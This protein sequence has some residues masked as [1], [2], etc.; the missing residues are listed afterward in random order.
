MTYFSPQRAE[1]SLS[2]RLD[3]LTKLETA[4]KAQKEQL[5]EAVQKDLNKPRFEFFAAELLAILD[6]IRLFKGK[7]AKWMKP[8]RVGSNFF[9]F[10][11]K[12]KIYPE[13]YGNVLII[14]PWNYPVQLAILPLIG[15]LAAG[16]RVMLK[17]SPLCPHVSDVLANLL[18]GCFAEDLVKVS[19]GDAA[20]LEAIMAEKW[21]YIFFTGST[22]TGQKVMQKAAETL[23]PVTL[24]LGGKSPALILPDANITRTARRIVWGKFIN[25]G[26][27]CVAPDYVL[28][29]KEQESA[30]I[31][32]LKQE[33]FNAYGENPEVSP[34]YGRIISENHT[35]RLTALLENAGEILVGGDA[36]PQNRYFAPTLVKITNLD[37]PLMNE[38]IF[39]PILPIITYDHLDGAK[40]V[41]KS[42]PRPL[43][44]YFFTKDESQ[45]EKL[46][47]ELPSGGV[48]IND[49]IMHVSHPNVP[50]GGIGASG[51]GS[52]HG[53][54]S[55]DTF[56][57]RRTVVSRSMKIDPSLRYP[58]YEG[59][60]KIFKWLGL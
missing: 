29:P 31:T 59:K 50:F 39:G 19:T 20:E 40:A 2:Q 37:Q 38:E 27:T 10:K 47:T 4:V 6:E 17:L 35:R 57:H 13:A 42:R 14:A 25:A 53:K 36:N 23:T 48:M 3:L 24:E 11:A 45:A 56:T 1:L 43:A 54:F 51:M 21:D 30:L 16:N 34:D 9:H 46:L 33:I 12:A 32:A 52:Y 22:S 44:L 15:A 58:P 49:T 55:F 26:Q 7:L 60:C 5:F 41:I 28:V 18:K 8:Q